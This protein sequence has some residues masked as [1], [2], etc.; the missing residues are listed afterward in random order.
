MAASMIQRKIMAFTEKRSDAASDRMAID[1]GRIDQRLRRACRRFSDCLA[2][3][4][5]IIV[6]ACGFQPGTQPGP[7]FSVP[8]EVNGQNAGSAVLDTGGGY[9]LMLRERY[10]LQVV[11]EVDVLLFGGRERAALTEPFPYVVGGLPGQADTAFVGLSVCDCNGV[12]I[13]FFRKSGV[14]VALDFAMPAAAFVATVPPGGTHLPF[15]IRPEGSPTFNTSFLTVEVSDG[16]QSITLRALLDTGTN[17][18]LLR[19]GLIGQPSRQDADRS[20]VFVSQAQLGTL[21]V[22][23]RLFDTPGL[24]DL[25]LGTD[26]LG[27]WGE[28]WYFTYTESGGHVTFFARAPENP[29]PTLLTT[30]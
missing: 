8:L 5:L 18:S 2:V 4:L 3:G 23:V 9:E 7:L 11:G 1:T 17:A 26:A 19:R 21:S 29:V 24:P 30:E 28:R 27:A 25:I 6:S 12:G 16:K 10:G 15:E 14:V 22:P 20:Q 13:H